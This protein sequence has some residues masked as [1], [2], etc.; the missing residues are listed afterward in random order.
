LTFFPGASPTAYFWTIFSVRVCGF[1]TAVFDEEGN[2]D[3]AAFSSCVWN[4]SR[5]VVVVYDATRAARGV[6]LQDD[7]E[8]SGCEWNASRR[9]VVVY[10]ETR[11]AR[12]VVLRVL[13]VTRDMR[14]PLWA[15]SARLLL[16]GVIMVV[17]G[18]IVFS[19]ALR[20]V[21]SQPR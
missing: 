14:H 13:A 3:G 15:A 2:G 11:A 8:F 19:E 18:R 1:W 17:F 4:A 7:A 16:I 6:V 20:C 5:R 21:R 10:D 9:V 12:E